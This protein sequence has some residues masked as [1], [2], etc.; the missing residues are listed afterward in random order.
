MN[1][2]RKAERVY[3]AKEG[4]GIKLGTGSV[5]GELVLGL[6]T[7]YKIKTIHVT[8]AP[9]LN[10]ADTA[11]TK[12]FSILGQ[13]S[14][15]ATVD[16]KEYI[17]SPAQP[18]ETDSITIV[19]LSSSSNR[20]YVSRIELEL[21]EDPWAGQVRV[22]MPYIVDFGSV[23]IVDGEPA[24]DVQSIAI[25][26]RNTNAPLTLRLRNG[27]EYSLSAPTLP[28]EGGEVDIAMLASREMYYYDTLYVASQSIPV[29]AYAYK[30]TAPALDTIDC[31]LDYSYANGKQDSALKSAVGEIAA[32]GIRYKYGSGTAHSWDGFY[33]TDRDTTSNRVIDMYSDNERYFNSD[34]PTA[35]VGGFDIEHRLPKS[36]WGAD[37]NR[38]YC[39]LYH[40]VPADYSANRSK[41]N[42]APGMLT[43]TTFWNGNFA[44]GKN[45]AYPVSR[46][47]CPADRWKGDFA[48]T[49]FYI[50]A[51]Y[52][53]EL[54]WVETGEPGQCVTNRSYK[55][56]QPWLIDVLLQWHRMD[57]VSTEERERA[58]KVYRIQ[59]NRN[60][61]I[62][63]PELVEYIW[64][65]KQ[66]QVY[67]VRGTG[68]KTNTKTKTKTNTKTIRN[69]RLAI[70]REDKTYDAYGRLYR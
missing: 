38:A 47:F 36:W 43:D 19:A 42:H 7:T 4:Y 37:V 1:K 8:A 16:L 50:A 62:D 31:T 21:A 41:C 55:E 64:G 35:S 67:T 34:K 13:T 60:P 33:H 11:H 25:T 23:A 24:S 40:L 18:I 39:D 61:F 49:Y 59:G 6:D 56:F 15:W 9:Y 57:T 51:T 29:K 46:V 28:A 14:K 22:T 58:E 5:K 65:D 63:H 12:G 10:K 2:V 70:V 32:C 54:T 45:P 52:G 66:G 27:K 69:G 26:A 3:R 53:D 44:T 68:M 17:L 30:Y 48:R 20:F